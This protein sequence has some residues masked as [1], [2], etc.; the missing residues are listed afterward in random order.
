MAAQPLPE[1]FMRRFFVHLYKHL[2]YKHLLWHRSPHNPLDT[3]IESE[4][5]MAMLTLSW[6]KAR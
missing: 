2:L 6:K 3:W 1:I 4:G 5:Q